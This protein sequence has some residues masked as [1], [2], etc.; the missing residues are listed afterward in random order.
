MAMFFARRG[1]VRDAAGFLRD[2]RGV[3]A[4][5]MAFVLPLFLMVV[6]G[7]IEFGRALSA[8]NQAS[9]ALGRVVRIVNLDATTST[10]EI[11]SAMRSY[12][13][14]AYGDGLSVTATKKT[15]SGGE[16]IE[17]S[18]S[19]PYEIRVPFTSLSTLTLSVDTLAPL[20]SATK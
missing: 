10:S 8:W 3:A 1:S 12:L 5:E 7:T 14:S 15:I 16:Y 4:V 18:A 17:I 6:L 11:A 13:P 9:H 2:R 20:I 19:F